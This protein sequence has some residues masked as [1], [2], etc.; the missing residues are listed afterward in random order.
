LEFKDFKGPLKLNSRTF[1]DQ[2]HLQ[3]LSRALKT[4]T[5]FFKDFQALSGYSGHP[6][7]SF[8]NSIKAMKEK[9][10]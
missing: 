7:E 4:E 9:L 6:A 3:R 2:I 1:R 5:K 10:L 8:T